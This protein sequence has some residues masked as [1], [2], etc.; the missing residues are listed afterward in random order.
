MVLFLFNL[1]LTNSHPLAPTFLLLSV[2]TSSFSFWSSSPYFEND[3]SNIKPSGPAA[4]P[5]QRGNPPA[6]FHSSHELV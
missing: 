5:L 2:F 1:L 4:A 6:C 3:V